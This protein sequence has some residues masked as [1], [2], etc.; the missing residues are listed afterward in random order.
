[1]EQPN[2]NDKPKSRQGNYVYSREAKNRHSTIQ[3]Q[4]CIINKL[5]E[6][7]SVKQSTKLCGCSDVSYYRWKKYDEEFKDKIEEYFQ[8]ELEQA[9]EILKQSLKENPNLLQFFLKHRHPEYKVKQSIELNHTGLDK[10]E[11]RV[12][13]PTNY[14]ETTPEDPEVL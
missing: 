7:K 1:M 4:N 8:I 12:I 2:Q 9:E 13:L 10:I 14:Q 5:A 6:G 3:K 11:V